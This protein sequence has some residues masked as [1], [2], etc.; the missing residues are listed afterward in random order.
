MEKYGCADA[1]ADPEGDWIM[2]WSCH[3]FIPTQYWQ[4]LPSHAWRFILRDV[5]TSHCRID[6][7]KE[8]HYDY[9]VAVLPCL[10]GWRAGATVIFTWSQTWFWTKFCTTGTETAVN[11]NRR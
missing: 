1:E 6:F 2:A 4:G 3:R 11:G 5:K 8:E 9:R 10:Q 7:C